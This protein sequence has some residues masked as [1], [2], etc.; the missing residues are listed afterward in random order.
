M[1]KTS[2][3]LSLFLIGAII[4]ATFSSYSVYAQTASPTPTVSATIKPT[5]T[6]SVTITAT[7]TPTPTATESTLVQP[8]SSKVKV[9]TQYPWNKQIPIIM[10]ITPQYDG[11]SLE[12]RWPSVSGFII[13][14]QTTKWQN[15]TKG[16]TYTTTFT[17]EPIA[18][19]TQKVSAS[20]ILTTFQTNYIASQ[21]VD[22][23]L[24]ADKVVTPIT[25]GYKNYETMMY[26]LLGVGGFIILPL[27]VFFSFMYIKNKLI[28]QWI[29]ARL[30]E[31]I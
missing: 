16:T 4:V 23:T 14:P 26:V 1:Q 13:T 25:D 3:I 30:N 17:F 8:I 24:N 31:P 11:Q 28:P 21:P 9:D 10:E 12:I 6:T 27:F 22:I 18:T 15:V 20:L 5:I 7:P 2:K 19:G 29:Q